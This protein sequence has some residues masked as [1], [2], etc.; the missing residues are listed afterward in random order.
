MKKRPLSVTIIGWIFIL[1]C[2]VA[3][4]S[5]LVRVFRVSFTTD[6]TKFIV[7]HLSETG[8]VLAVRLLGVIGGMFL[9]RG[10][11]WARWVL[12]VWMGYHVIY[13]ATSSM[14]EMLVHAVFLV[15][16]VCFLFGPNASA[17]FRN[18]PPDG[19]SGK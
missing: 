12:V 3:F 2:A 15:V 6:D 19:P 10:C 9:L 14:R 11:N 7:V 8:L 4:G 16:L 1:F 17:Y 13:S 5:E 18:A